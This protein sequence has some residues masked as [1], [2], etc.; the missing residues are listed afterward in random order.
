MVDISAIAGTVSALKGAMDISKA[1]IDLRDGQAM[2]GKVIELN[3][4]ILEAQSSAFAANDERT[5]LIARVGELEK[6]L[7]HLKAWD[8]DKQRYELKSVARGTVA[9]MLKPPERGSEPPHW[10]CATCYGKSKKAF[11]QNT[12]AHFQR[13]SI[14]MCGECQAKVATDGDPQWING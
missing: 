6:E 3:S 5:A 4:K 11:L 1:M 2:Q 10:L 8:A 12:G 9:Y 14:Y 7:A 13:S